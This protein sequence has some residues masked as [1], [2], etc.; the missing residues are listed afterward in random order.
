VRE[1]LLENRDRITKCFME[2][3]D[4]IFENYSPE[5]RDAKMKLYY[6]A[7]NN[8]QQSDFSALAEALS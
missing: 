2:I 8:W 6:R 4:T 7:K 1:Y 5:D 3:D